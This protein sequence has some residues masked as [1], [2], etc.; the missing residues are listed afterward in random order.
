LSSKTKQ[1]NKTTNRKGYQ[2]R[3]KLKLKRNRQNAKPYL[4]ATSPNNCCCH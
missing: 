1:I 4:H 3:F 2:V